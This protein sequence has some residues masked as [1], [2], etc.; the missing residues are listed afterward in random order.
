MTISRRSFTAG[1]AALGAAPLMHP[2]AA[3]AARTDELNILCWEG[4]N[5]DD[6]L[7]PFRDLNPGA[8]VRA[9]SGTSDPDMINKLR[10]GEVNVWDLINLNQPWARGQLYPSGLI[11]PLDKERFMPFFEK[12]TP[13]YG[14]PPYPLAFAEDGELIGMP[15]RYGPFSFVVNTD[16]IS[17]ATAEEQGWKL[18][19]DPAMAGRYG[20]LTYDNWNL[21]HM[22]LTAD[23]NPFKP[24]DDA[25]FEAFT[26]VAAKIFAGSKLMSDDLVAMNTALINGEIDAYFTGGTYTASPARLDGLTNIRG[27][28]PASGPI[29]GKGGVVWAE[30]TSL[31]NNPDPSPL[32]SD[33]LEFVQQPEICKAVGFA[34]GTYNPVAQMGDPEVFA[35]W[36]EDELD[37][38]QWDTL[39]EESANSVEYDSVADYDKLM[40]IYTAARRG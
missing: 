11:K 25:G 31:V 22:C 30:L 6:V 19:L 3:R 32:A 13:E 17:R 15:Q 14:S 20:I 24:L 18:F 35:Q 16:K 40:E 10:A 9:E 23:L 7:G 27:I 21:I 33:F 5:T 28:T 4:Y 38:I 1:L 2:G 36:D 12:M 29:D 26:D 8:T 37:A 39:E 34:E